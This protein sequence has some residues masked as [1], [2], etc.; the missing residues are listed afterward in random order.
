MKKSELLNSD[1]PNKLKNQNEEKTY[2][3]I[4]KEIVEKMKND[5]NGTKNTPENKFGVGGVNRPQKN[6]WGPIHLVVSKGML[7]LVGGR[8]SILLML[9]YIIITYHCLHLLVH[10]NFKSRQ[11]RMRKD[12]TGL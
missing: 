1:V 11:C 7:I 2:S 5:K 3:Q 4:R 6:S 8:R 10:K 12:F 9:S